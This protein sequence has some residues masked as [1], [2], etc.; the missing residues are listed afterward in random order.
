MDSDGYSD[1]VYNPL[2][3]K[4]KRTISLNRKMC[5]VNQYLN[6]FYLL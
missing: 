1:D 3:K 5:N 6:I 2:S 4:E